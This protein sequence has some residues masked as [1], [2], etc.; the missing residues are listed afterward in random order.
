M[1]GYFIVYVGYAMMSD[2]AS[3][4]NFAVVNMPDVDPHVALICTVFS[5][6][7]LRVVRRPPTGHHPC[8]RRVH[9]Y[10]K[11]F[12]HP[13]ETLTAS[14]TALHRRTCR[15]C[16]YSRATF[17]ILYYVTLYGYIHVMSHCVILSKLHTLYARR[18]AL[19]AP[20]STLQA[21]RSTF[22]APRSTLHAPRSMIQDSSTFTL[23]DNVVTG[24]VLLVCD[25][26][27]YELH[28]L[29]ILNIYVCLSCPPF[30]STLR[31]SLRYVR[32]YATLRYAT[33]WYISFAIVFGSYVNASRAS[34]TASSAV[35]A[36]YD[37]PT[38][39]TLNVVVNV[40]SL[41]GRC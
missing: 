30:N 37:L 21:P 40:L 36:Y 2:N 11:R 31:S 1:I 12:S 25:T 13:L 8:I 26:S 41:V 23:C 24:N 3:T 29:D 5:T 16:R 17:A 9:R 15:Q 6:L 28:T 22:Q 33:L 35:P 19:D 18:S 34:L 39:W 4:L 14:L 38:T 10:G 27:F 32:R 20:R 7:T